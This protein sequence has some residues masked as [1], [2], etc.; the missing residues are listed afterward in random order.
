M[1]RNPPDCQRSPGHPAS[2]VKSGQEA[3]VGLGNAETEMQ[4]EL[5]F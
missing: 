1:T 3:N 5:C 2:L 4:I